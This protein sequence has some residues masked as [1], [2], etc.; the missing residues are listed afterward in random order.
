MFH[1]ASFHR[2]PCVREGPSEPGQEAFGD[3]EAL[4]RSTG[5]LLVPECLCLSR[6]WFAVCLSLDGHSYT[7]SLRSIALPRATIYCTLHV[8]TFL[9][10]GR[11]R[12]TIAMAHST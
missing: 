3:D 12:R 11:K 6:L 8:A 10:Y 4:S 9:L 7:A 5:W 1:H 2:A